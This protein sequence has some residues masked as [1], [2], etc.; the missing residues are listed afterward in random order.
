MRFLS[1]THGRYRSFGIRTEAGVIDLGARL[2]GRVADLGALLA[3]L[4][5]GMELPELRG[6]EADFGLEEIG[7]LPPIPAPGK[8]LCVGL[9]YAEH[10]EE[11]GGRGQHAHPT[12]FVRFADSLVGHRQP[13]RHPGVSDQYDYEAELAVVIGRTAFHLPAERAWDVVAG[14]SGFMDGSVRDFQFHTSQFTPGKNF[15]E[16]GAFGPEL[17]TTDEV[18]D[19]FDNRLIR[20]EVNGEERQRARLGEMIFSI[21]ELLAYVSQWTVLRP[22][23]VI[24]T[25]TPGGVGFA[26]KPPRF[27]RPGDR[28]VVEIEG[29]GRLENPVRA[30]D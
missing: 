2:G 11:T 20:C 16:S 15:L 23:D 18:R 8:I 25:G 4:D 26:R 1:F 30:A 7:W 28:V 6:A 27:L 3:L 9:N 14:V 12:L 10:R 22:G 24:A 19:G 17:V 29:I 21:P 13:L 5:R